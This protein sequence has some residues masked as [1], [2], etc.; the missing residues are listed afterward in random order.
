MPDNAC[1]RGAGEAAAKPIG[2]RLF[3]TRRSR[4]SF[5]DVFEAC[6]S[7]SER[8][9]ASVC[10][11]L[12]G[13]METAFLATPDIGIARGEG[14]ANPRHDEKGLTDGGESIFIRQL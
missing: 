2:G 7:G 6:E 3:L 14:S 5:S 1:V 11:V 12:D 4:G 9:A 13:M 10:A 8:L